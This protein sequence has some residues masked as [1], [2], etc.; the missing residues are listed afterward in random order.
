MPDEPP[1]TEYDQAGAYGPMEQAVREA[2]RVLPDFPGFVARGWHE[3]PCSHNGIYDPDY[4]NIEIRYSFGRELSDDPM[5]R[6]EY[7]DVLRDH[8]EEQ[9]YAVRTDDGDGAGSYNLSVTREDG[10][11]L[12]YK[13]WGIVSLVVQSGCVPVCDVS[14]IEYIPPAGGIEPGSDGD[15]V[16]DYFP[17]GIPSGKT[18]ADAIAP[19]GETQ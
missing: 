9:G 5:I 13:V 15:G 8:W 12:W 16:K 2:V 7:I 18:S 11:S 19:F 17:E 4:T 10:I 1:D 14:G 6:G 3:L